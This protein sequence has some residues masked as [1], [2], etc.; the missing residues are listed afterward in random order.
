MNLSGDLPDWVRGSTAVSRFQGRSDF[1][2]PDARALLCLAQI[3]YAPRSEEAAALQLLRSWGLDRVEGTV[4]DSRRAPDGNL[5]GVFA[6]AAAG[7][8]AGFVAFRGSDPL[9]LPRWLL[10]YT[11]ATGLS[12]LHEGF[13]DAARSLWDRLE[14][15]IPGNPKLA[16]KPLFFTGHG[17]GAAMAAIAALFARENGTTVAGVYAF[18]MPRV[19]KMHFARRYNALLGGVTYR[20]VYQQ[21][22]VPAV[23]TAGEGFHHVGRY[24]PSRPDTGRFVEGLLTPNPAPQ[25]ENQWCNEPLRDPALELSQLGPGQPTLGFAQRVRM[26]LGAVGIRPAS[27]VLGDNLLEAQPE[28]LRD[29]FTDRYWEALNG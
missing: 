6:F 24:L 23:P 10:D 27:S 28:P 29:H 20:L 8:S 22:I 11:I 25:P 2:L 17:I 26:G 13:E 14:T 18:G 7:S 9:Q 4:V 15:V 5:S 12:G 21:D 1:A 19:G 16:G 3:A